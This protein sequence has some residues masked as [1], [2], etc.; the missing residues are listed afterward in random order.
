MVYGYQVFDYA[1]KF[2][3]DHV[4]NIY[5]RLFKEP[6]NG[7]AYIQGICKGYF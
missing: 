3:V 2:G 1:D 4:D 6:P 5:L 7:V